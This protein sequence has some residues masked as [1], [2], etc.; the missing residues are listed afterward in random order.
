MPIQTIIF[1]FGNVV[2]FFDHRR[3]AGNLARHSSWSED[4][5]LAALFGC[6]LEDDYESGRIS[7][8]ELLRRVRAL[9]PFR[10]TDTELE[11]AFAEIFWPNPDVS[12]LVGR[13]KPR[14]RLLL[15]SNTNDLHYRHFRETF[16]GTLAHFE[17]LVLSFEVGVRKPHAGFFEH[18]LKHA[19]CPADACLF[20]DDVPANVAGAQACG[21]HG[22]IYRNP[23]DLRE[24]LAELDIAWE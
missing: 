22:I 2:G 12:E 6:N 13:L 10:C 21:L 19:R 23:A 1:D 15:G 24:R 14:Y 20:I 7:T 18:C 17:H 3:A 5:L 8:P 11:K 9:C 16:A 4:Q